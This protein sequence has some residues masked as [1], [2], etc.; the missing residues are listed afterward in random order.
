MARLV[1]ATAAL[2]VLLS[3]GAALRLGPS[4]PAQPEPPTHV[5]LVV[6][7]TLRADHLGAYGYER[8]VSPNLDALARESAV[9]ESV[10][11]LSSWTKPSVTTILTSISPA[12]HGVGYQAS[13]LPEGT[14]TLARAL[15]AAG[16]E[17]LGWSANVNVSAEAGLAQGFDAFEE[18]GSENV[19]HSTTPEIVGKAIARIDPGRRQLFFLHLIGPHGPYVPSDEARAKLAHGRDA[20]VEERMKHE[21]PAVWY[22]IDHPGQ[23]DYLRSLYDAEILDEDAAIAPLL[24]AIRER[25]LDGRSLFVLTS[26]HG[27]AFGEHG[28]MEHGNTLFHEEI[29]VPLLIR[30]PGI[31]PTRHPTVAGLHDVAPTVLARVGVEP[32]KT[33][34]GIDLLGADVRQTNG[35]TIRLREFAESDD[36][37]ELLGVIADGKKAIWSPQDESVRFLFEDWHA[38]ANDLDR[39]Q[40]HEDEM[41]ELAS[42]GGADPARALPPSSMEI[43]EETRRKMEALGYAG[44]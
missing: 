41:R 29:H 24:A 2:L 20:A 31:A 34:G 42:R 11:S 33:F 22:R 3:V 5:F 21:F 25:G 16:F 1:R 15:H 40:A 38:D 9:F 4:R 35:R 6:Y 44:N 23:I 8:P 27:E 12:D 43:S 37:R 32:P 26:D 18:V 19:R 36:D 17:T 10:V 13:R 39:A 7:D 30:G 14:P 28:T